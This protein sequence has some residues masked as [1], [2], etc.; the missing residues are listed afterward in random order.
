[1]RPLIK[2]LSYWAI[3]VRAWS[4]PMTAASVLLSAAY[5]YYL[6]Y[7]VYLGPLALTLVGALVLHMSVNVLNDYYDYVYG[8]DRPDVLT[9]R[10]H[11]ILMGILK[12]RAM[13]NLGMALIITGSLIGIYLFLIA[14]LPVLITGAL[15]LVLLYG[16][17]GPP[18]KLKYRALGELAV[19]TTWGPLMA[20]GSMAA[21]TLGHINYLVIAA[22]TP[23]ALLVVATLYA[24][25]VRDAVRDRE[26]GAVT[27]A[28]ILGD[29]ARWL[30]AALVVGSYVAQLTMVF[31]GALPTA[32]LLTL[33]TTLNAAGMVSKAMRNS[34][35]RLD[36]ATAR[37]SLLYAAL[38][39]AGLI[40]SKI[41]M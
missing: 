29:K 32:T 38:M 1:M 34:F 3:I 8:F 22:V 16:Y 7:V 37:F 36:E 14:G 9:Y 10:P 2:Y 31:M 41:G 4:L 35:E 21:S 30:Y 11:A 40:I 20:I 39:I 33:A 23:V 15:G 17:T 19:F 18:L 6:G 24:N 26:G 25:N 13:L 12:P 28:A 5:A 27:I